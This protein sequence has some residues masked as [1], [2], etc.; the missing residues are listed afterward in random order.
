MLTVLATSF[1][2]S[3]TSHDEDVPD[4]IDLVNGDLFKDSVIGLLWYRSSGVN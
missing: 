3:S 1:S 2:P 4:S